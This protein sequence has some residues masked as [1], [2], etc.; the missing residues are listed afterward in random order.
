MFT[1]RKISRYRNIVNRW[2]QWRA[3]ELGCDPLLVTAAAL[4]LKEF[5]AALATRVPM[6][7]AGAACFCE[8][9]AEAL[10]CRRGFAWA[11]IFTTGIML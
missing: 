3:L 8:G 5:N 11:T 4:R 1:D 9:T 7:F 6:E 10:P 2:L